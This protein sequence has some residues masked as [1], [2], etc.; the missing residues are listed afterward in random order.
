M[1]NGGRPSSNDFSAM[2]T[3]TGNPLTREEYLLRKA[4]IDEAREKL[5]QMELETELQEIMRQG[6]EAEQKLARMR[7]EDAS[8]RLAAGP[9]SA[10]LSSYYPQANYP[11][12]NEVPLTA[13]IDGEVQDPPPNSSR[14][15]AQVPPTNYDYQRNY[16]TASHPQQASLQSQFS[17][18]H[19]STQAQPAARLQ[20]S[21]ARPYSRAPA[22]SIPGYQ[23]SSAS[24]ST[25]IYAYQQSRTGQSYQQ[26]Q[27][28]EEY[29]AQQSQKYAAELAA[30]NTRPP[31]QTSS[32]GINP[33]ATL[34]SGTR[35]PQQV[36]A[37]RQAPLQTTPSEAVPAAPSTQRPKS[38]TETGSFL[39]H[40]S[41]SNDTAQPSIT[42]QEFIR[43]FHIICARDAS[44]IRAFLSTTPAPAE[45]L[46]AAASSVDLAKLTN[47]GAIALLNDIR[48]GPEVPPP[49]QSTSTSTSTD[50]RVTTVVDAP[51]KASATTVQPSLS[52]TDL[53]STQQK[54]R[55]L[56]TKEKFLVCFHEIYQQAGVDK[57]A[58]FFLRNQ[59]VVHQEW[60]QALMRSLTPPQLAEMHSAWNR[61]H[62]RFQ[63][64]AKAR[65]ASSGAGKAVPIPNH[66]P[67]NTA[68][69]NR[70]QTTT[71][72]GTV[73][74][75]T[76]TTIEL[77]KPVPV[78]P[79]P[80]ITRSTQDQSTSAQPSQASTSPN[81]TT[82][83]MSAAPAIQT[84][85]TSVTQVPVPTVQKRPS[86]S[87]AQPNTVTA[88]LRRPPTGT[89][90]HG[91]AAGAN[92]RP[93][94]VPPPMKVPTTD[95]STIKLLCTWHAATTNCRTSGCAG[96]TYHIDSASYSA[97]ETEWNYH[98]VTHTAAG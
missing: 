65:L 84:T 23:H 81:L 83:T 29:W 21:N 52:P 73:A 82:A 18:Q 55:S 94:G 20:G 15:P 19:Q 90:D 45:W 88:V 50:V 43:R 91:Q 38:S 59:S 96:S 68:Q 98:T 3:F 30:T 62:V 6:R 74:R 32:A 8:A 16:L 4:K 58:D 46:T 10:S 67:N 97:A 33:Q 24:A 78:P 60:Q 26:Q 47:A 70:S 12:V 7:A 87:L 36:H 85:S 48:K 86:V 22:F 63:E 41:S 89:V 44:L 54:P 72:S 40:Q 71:S 34:L 2:G 49:L 80:S 66:V 39:D 35:A 51:S 9:S 77:P 57:A 37:Q 1:D 13:R 42:K 31:G 27:L 11:S 14:S 64:A 69:P 75:P 17:S 92:Y 95:G 79:R 61:A 53:S 56:D 93:Y 76:P 28:S 5:V 25:P